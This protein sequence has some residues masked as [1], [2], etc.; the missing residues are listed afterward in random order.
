MPWWHKE[1]RDQQPWYSVCGVNRS[2]TRS[3]FN[4]RCITTLY[5]EMIENAYI[6]IHIVQNKCSATS[7]NVDDIP[8]I[9]PEETFIII[10]LVIDARKLST[11]VFK[12]AF[13]G[14]PVSKYRSTFFKIR[15]NWL[16]PCE[17]SI[18]LLFVIILNNLSEEIDVI[19]I[20]DNL[21][22]CLNTMKCT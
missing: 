13:G 3:D 9:Y 1:P 8:R 5:W 22:N 21:I 12:T 17:N 6:Y 2:S 14:F 7:V 20:C 15:L 10:G 11:L 19:H 4:Y 18:T 16:E